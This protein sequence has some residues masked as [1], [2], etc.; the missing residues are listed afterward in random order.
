MSVWDRASRHLFQ[1]DLMG[2]GVLSV[3]PDVSDVEDKAA[4]QAC[5]A[6]DVS[7]PVVEFRQ[8]PHPL[9]LGRLTQQ[10]VPMSPLIQETIKISPCQAGT[11]GIREFGILQLRVT[12]NG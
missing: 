7:K 3:R 6:F 9:G 2:T 8:K 10:I 5:I 4:R 1:H 11:L 12:L